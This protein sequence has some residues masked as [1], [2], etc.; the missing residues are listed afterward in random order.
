M[1]RCQHW[2]IKYKP[3]KICP[4][5]ISS[6]PPLS[7]TLSQPFAMFLFCRLLIVCY[8]NNNSVMLQSWQTFCM[9]KNMLMVKI[10]NSG[11]VAMTRGKASL[12][13]MTD[14]HLFVPWNLRNKIFC[15]ATTTKKK[16]EEKKRIG[17]KINSVGSFTKNHK[18][19]ARIESKVHS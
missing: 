19:T 14:F 4:K 17:G 15:R 10:R 3:P 7:R 13:Y 16:E 12:M 8:I 5:P 6:L 2:V 1:A 9:L 18:M 11:I